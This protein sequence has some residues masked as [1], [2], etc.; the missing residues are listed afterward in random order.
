ML[1][2]E[3]HE[4]SEQRGDDDDEQGE[5]AVA[6]DAF[7]VAQRAQAVDAA[8]GEIVHEARIAGG[9]AAKM[10]AHAVPQRGQ[11]V[12][13]HA[14]FVEEFGGFAICARREFGMADFF[15]NR[16]AG[17]GRRRGFFRG[18]GN[19]FAKG[20]GGGAEP[21]FGRTL[22]LRVELFDF[23]FE[24]G[25]LVVE[26]ARLVGNRVGLFLGQAHKNLMPRENNDENS[27]RRE[28]DEQQRPRQREADFA[29]LA[30]A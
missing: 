21:G 25:N 27:E 8:G 26:R 15:K 19:G 10:I 1:R 16:F 14:E 11:I 17:R 13:A 7:F 28:R 22:Q 6:R 5:K 24:R 30:K 3:N 29:K 12:F 20:Q 4:E 18:A 9:R 2:P 23:R